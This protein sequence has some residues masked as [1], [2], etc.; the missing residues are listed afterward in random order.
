MAKGKYSWKIIV[1]WVLAL[2]ALVFF[3]FPIFYLLNTAFKPTE[4]TMSV[5][6]AWIFRPSLEHFTTVIT[7]RVPPGSGLY[8]GGSGLFHRYFLNSMII[9]FFSVMLAVFIG[10]LA[11]YSLARFPLRRKEDIAFWII[12]IRMGPQLG[13]IIPFYILSQRLGMYDSHPTVVF[14]YLS[15]T[16]P[17]VVWMMRG[18]YEDVPVEIEEAAMVDGCSRFQAFRKVITPLVAPG[19]AATAIFSLILTWNDFIFAFIL[20]GRFAKTLPVGI[21][22]FITPLGIVFG[23]MA[24]ASTLVMAPV[25]V[26]ALIVQ[27]HLVR[28]LTFGAIK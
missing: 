20:T 13:V 22:E 23:P 6:P 4:L 12:S 1:S 10:S 15:F 8:Y 11:A 17:F 19:L 9:S 27:K 7:G 25:L 21:T 26:F 5:P 18:F 28:G 16:I 3:C 2:M 14:V 24:A